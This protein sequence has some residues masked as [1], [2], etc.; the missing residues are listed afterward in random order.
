MFKLALTISAL[1][2]SVAA[3][4]ATEANVEG[5]DDEYKRFADAINPYGY[6]WEAI[7]VT[8]EDGF[9]LTTFHVT[10]NPNGLFTPTKPP[11]IIQHG[12]YGDAAEWMG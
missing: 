10:G 1:A 2:A 11:V 7:K 8:T 6:T 12:D 3:A 5:Q 4:E 9:I